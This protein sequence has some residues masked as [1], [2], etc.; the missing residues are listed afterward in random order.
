MFQRKNATKMDL[1]KQVVYKFFILL[2]LCFETYNLLDTGYDHVL[3]DDE[4]R[5]SMGQG[6]VFFEI[7]EPEELAFTYKANPASFTPVWNTTL[8]GVPLVSTDPPCSCGFINNHDEVE[9]KIAFIERG[10]CSFVSK[11]VRAEAAGAIGVIITDQD[12]END[13]L[14]ISMVDDTT[15]RNV[16]I[17]A[18]F[19]LGKN[20]QIIK[21]WLDR[22][23]L[24]HALV[25]I[26]V[27]IS[28]IQPHKLNQPP[29][30]V[31]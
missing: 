10:E 24:S 21:R 25:N 22:L 29:W 27:N 17:P 4:Y 15:S 26:P 16:N 11:V 3:T 5:L 7:T 1:K 18:V 9:G 8:T 14:Y 13:E 6:Y 31:W 28:R 20:G 12:E 30:M 2:A 19:L 23:Q